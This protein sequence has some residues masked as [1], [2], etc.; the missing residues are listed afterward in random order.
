MVTESGWPPSL[1]LG[2]DRAGG[3][4]DDDERAA[5]V[6]VVGGGVHRDEGPVAPH[7]HRGRLAGQRDRAVGERIGRVRDVPERDQ[8]A[9]A[10]RRDQGVAAL[11][12]RDDLGRDAAGVLVGV[13]RGDPPEVRLAGYGFGGRGGCA[14]DGRGEH[15]CGERRHGGGGD[16][17]RDLRIWGS[18]RRMDR[19]VGDGPGCSYGTPVTSRCDRGERPVA[20]R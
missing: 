13:R 8:S 14:R 19:V 5:R 4:I 1:V 3:D 2:D 17:G 7:R 12:R 16:R 20:L 9:G 6:H 11:G 10:V 18:F 15:A